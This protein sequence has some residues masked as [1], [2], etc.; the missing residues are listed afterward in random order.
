MV[1]EYCA[2]RIK[3]K[4]KGGEETGRERECK[5]DVSERESRETCAKLTRQEQDSEL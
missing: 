4:E 2:S 1:P 3:E 5:Q